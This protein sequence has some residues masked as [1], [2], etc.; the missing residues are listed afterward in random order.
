M[1]D[2]CPR[3]IFRGD[4]DPRPC[5]VRGARARNNGDHCGTGSVDGGR[6]LAG[7]ADLF[8]REPEKIE[9]GKWYFEDIES[10]AGA[11]FDHLDPV[12]GAKLK[13]S[14]IKDAH[15]TLYGKLN[16]LLQCL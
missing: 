10:I 6:Q 14:R 9:K 1:L 5:P 3:G 4:V 12:F 16:A 13:R 8:A 15:A 2:L 11:R 7:N